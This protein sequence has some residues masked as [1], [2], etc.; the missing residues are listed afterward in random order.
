MEAIDAAGA[1][2]AIPSQTL[3]IADGRLPDNPAPDPRAQPE[4]LRTTR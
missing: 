4:S 1:V 2:I 3:H